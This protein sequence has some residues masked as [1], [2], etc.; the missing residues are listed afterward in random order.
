MKIGFIGAGTV[1]QILAKHVLAHD[2][3]VIVSNSRGPES[4]AT[5]VAELGS[6][7]AAGTA[8]SSVCTE[9]CS[10]ARRRPMALCRSLH[11]LCP[12]L[13]SRASST[14]GFDRL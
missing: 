11:L 6:G 1:A 7:A 12:S 2:H 14:N 9:T 8:M 13:L 4:L 10:I 5:L 3:Q